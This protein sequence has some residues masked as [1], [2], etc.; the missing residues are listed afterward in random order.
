MTENKVLTNQRRKI[1]GKKG[2]KESQAGIREK[3]RFQASYAG[4]SLERLI[5]LGLDCP[6]LDAYHFSLEFEDIEWLQIYENSGHGCLVR[7]LFPF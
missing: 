7:G 4:R 1:V 5:S 3:P 6:R 2:S